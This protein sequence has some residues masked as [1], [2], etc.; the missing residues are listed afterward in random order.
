MWPDTNV[1]YQGNWENDMRSGY[2]TSTYPDG[3]KYEGNFVKNLRSGNGVYTHTD[4]SAYVGAWENDMKE[5][6]GIFTWAD[7][8]KFSGEWH[9]GE[10]GNGMLIETDGTQRNIIKKL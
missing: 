10:S 1:W 5:G 9:E 2:G 6:K 8:T 3:G 4:G 7:G